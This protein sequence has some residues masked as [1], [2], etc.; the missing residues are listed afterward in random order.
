MGGQSGNFCNLICPLAQH[1]RAKFLFKFNS[2]SNPSALQ[3]AHEHES[4][5]K[6]L[7]D[8]KSDSFKVSKFLI[9]A[10]LIVSLFVFILLREGGGS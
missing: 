10:Q 6:L 1:K 7:Y 5:P 3:W 9:L 8:G 4:R 2:A